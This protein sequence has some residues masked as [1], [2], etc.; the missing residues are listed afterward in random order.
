MVNR[1]R[2]S[3]PL[4][5]NKRHGAKFRIGCRV[6]QTSEEGQRTYR[7]KHCEYGNKDDGCCSKTLNNKN[8]QAS[9]QKC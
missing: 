4:G 6:K 7:P 3:D 9:S 1:I 2:T 5:L 8:Y